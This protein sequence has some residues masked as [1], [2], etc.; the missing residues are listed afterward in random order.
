MNNGPEDKTFFRAKEIGKFYHRTG[1]MPSFAEIGEITGLRSKN[2]VFKLVNR[3][4][5]NKVLARDEKGRLIPRSIALP[6]RMLG[7]VEAGFP[8]PAEEELAD[9][10]S[11]D[12]MLI[13]NPSATFLLKV[14]GDS[15]SGAGILPGDMVIIDKGQAPKSGDIVIAEVD[16]EW[17][18][19]YLKK[20]GDSVTL[21]PANPQYKPIKPKKEL[22]IAGV[23]TAVVR[24]YK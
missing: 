9:N 1:R 8:S 10:L 15:M 3:L 14:S 5:K 22:K 19:K 21:I 20:R 12:D 4:Q 11:L 7:T 6:L 17:T 24:K 16:G 23:V 13:Q 18:M 2:A